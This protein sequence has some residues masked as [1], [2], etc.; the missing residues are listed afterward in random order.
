MGVLPNPV[1]YPHAHEVKQ[2]PIGKDRGITGAQL[3]DNSNGVPPQAIIKVTLVQ[4]VIGP[5]LLVEPLFS[6]EDGPMQ[7]ASVKLAISSA[8]HLIGGGR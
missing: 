8:F 3:F 6:R 1:I 4:D 2:H 7:H 5:T